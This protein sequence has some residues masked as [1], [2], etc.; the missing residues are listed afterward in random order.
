MW[1]LEP[2][3]KNGAN[4]EKAKK[5]R[6]AKNK[7]MKFSDYQGGRDQFGRKYPLKIVFKDSKTIYGHSVA[8]TESGDKTTKITFALIANINDWCKN[9]NEKERE[10]IIFDDDVIEEV[11][12]FKEY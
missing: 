11:S 8:Y 2:T 3:L 6:K 5:S 7:T 12:I 9:I 1:R 4:S 10:R